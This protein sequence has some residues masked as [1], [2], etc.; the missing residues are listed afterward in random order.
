MK[1]N[2]TICKFMDLLWEQQQIVETFDA[3][4]CSFSSVKIHWFDKDT[5]KVF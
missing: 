5:V 1:V 3:M 4:Q 2:Q